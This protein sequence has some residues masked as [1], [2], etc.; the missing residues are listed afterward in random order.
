VEQTIH[1]EG[2]ALVDRAKEYCDGYSD[3]FHDGLSC[4]PYEN[5]SNKGW[6]QR[7]FERGFEV[8]RSKANQPTH[9]KE[10]LDEILSEFRV[11]DN[12]GPLSGQELER[13]K[14]L[15]EKVKAGGCKSWEDILLELYADLRTFIRSCVTLSEG[16]KA[17]LEVV[18]KAVVARFAKTIANRA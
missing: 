13:W 15:N 16:E 3:G 9:Q 17:A 4:W 12:H 8:G 1:T 6:Y 18:S 14:W 5:T 11:L 10:E 7:G 2:D